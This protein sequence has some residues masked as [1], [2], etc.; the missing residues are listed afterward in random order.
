MRAW[1]VFRKCL[2]E[3]LRDLWALLL[4][5]STAPAFVLL[6]WMITAGGS[7]TYGLLIIDHDR[8]V[9]AADGTEVSAARHVI[10]AIR[11][12]A[13]PDGQP[14]LDVQLIDERA[15]AEKKLKDHDA[16]AMVIFPDNFSAEV[17]RGTL[18]PG[19]V[20]ITLVGDLSNPYYA[21]ASIM[22]GVGLEAYLEAAMGIKGPVAFDEQALGG[23]AARTEFEAYVP[24][25]FNIALMMLVFLVAMA[26]ARD[27][28][29]GTLKRLQLSR[30]SA[31]DYLAGMSAAQVLIG[32]A[33]LLLTMGIATLCG[34]RSVGPLWAAVLLGVLTALAVVGVGLV[35]ACFAQTVTK[36]F[37]VANLPFMLLMFLSGS[38]FPLPKIELFS[39]GSQPVGLFDILPSTHAVV[40][41]N[42]VLSLGASVADIGFELVALTVLSLL[43]FGVGVVLFK[44]THLR[45]S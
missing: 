5:L 42:K 19:A 11:A 31:F 1:A 26:V 32:V 38:V 28:E 18:Q 15:L 44:R 35:I 21:V 33:G 41:F 16:A 29:A 4:A 12:V 17:A 45:A 30:M 2:R 3:Q 34:F 43:Y 13:Y 36:A 10:E 39:V 6:Y 20:K 27:V 7:M 25:V 37:L 40:A 22:A 9:T 23:S 8:P 24:G 14:M